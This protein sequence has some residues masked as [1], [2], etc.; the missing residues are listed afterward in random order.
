MP[1]LR[2]IV[3]LAQGYHDLELSYCDVNSQREKAMPTQD[4]KVS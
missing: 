1:H 4:T 3:Q 2:L